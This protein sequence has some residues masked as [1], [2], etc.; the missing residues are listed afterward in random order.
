MID[1]IGVWCPGTL[2]D[3]SLLKDI[4]PQDAE[5]YRASYGTWKI[6]Q[7]RDGV[8]LSGSLPKLLHGENVS[9]LSLDDIAAAVQLLASSTGI[10]PSLASVCV[11]E[12]GFTIPVEATPHEY[13]ASWASL[14]K[15]EKYSYGSGS[16]VTFRNKARSFTGYD[17]RR[18]M[19]GKHWPVNFECEH[20]LR[21]EL[22]LKKTV[23][24]TLGYPVSLAD[25]SSPS[26][27]IDLNERWLHTYSSIVKASKPRLQ[28]LKPTK[29]NLVRSLAAIGLAEA[30]I[31]VVEAQINELRKTGASSSVEAS[32]MRALIRELAKESNGDSTP[33]QREIDAK[34]EALAADVRRELTKE[35]QCHRCV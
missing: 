4:Q 33:L 16:T 20:A 11:L 31:E 3:P 2:V 18:E 19:Q 32:R 15:H 8:W 10:D 29:S 23:T 22:K 9:P 6:K 26:I 25:L 35:S 1:L 17:K 30:G 21:L 12:Y 27:L 13:L 5:S 7:C 24:R 34:V 14:S 28:L